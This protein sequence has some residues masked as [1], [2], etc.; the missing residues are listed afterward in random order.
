MERACRGAKT[1][2]ESFSS[3]NKLC[4]QEVIKELSDKT[5]GNAVIT[6]EVGC[7]QMWATQYYEFT[8]PRTFITSGGLGQWDM[9]CLRP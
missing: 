9:V 7:H 1:K 6:T 4:P 3:S 8:R 5:K 2:S